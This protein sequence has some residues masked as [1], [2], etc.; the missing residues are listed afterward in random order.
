MRSIG[1]EM[2]LAILIVVVVVFV[3]HFGHVQRRDYR[4][5]V[6]S[7]ECCCNGTCYSVGYCSSKRTEMILKRIELLYRCCRC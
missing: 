4:H 2:R 5:L 6:A 1:A 3:E 7:N